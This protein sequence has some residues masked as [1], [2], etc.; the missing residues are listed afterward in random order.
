[1]MG[2]VCVYLD[3]ILIFT[4]TKEEHAQIVAHMLEILWQNKLYL[5]LSKYDFEQTECEYLGHIL[6]H[7]SIKMD[8]I[9]VQAITDWPTP[10]NKKE[11]QQFLGFL[12]FYQRFIKDF[13]TVA[14]P[15]TS[16]TGKEPGS[17][18]IRKTLLLIN[19]RILQHLNRC[20]PFSSLGKKL[21]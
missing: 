3:D 19:W 8:P 12:N 16:L 17:G 11:V 10:K 6:A 9:K 5:K 20:W 13:G 15:M 14:K 1:M 18:V 2:K 7:N 4:E 21:A